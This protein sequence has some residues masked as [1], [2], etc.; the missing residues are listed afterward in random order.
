MRVSRRPGRDFSVADRTALA[1]RAHPEPEPCKPALTCWRPNAVNGLGASRPNLFRTTRRTAAPILAI[2][3]AVDT[4]APRW[5]VCIYI[6]T[7]PP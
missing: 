4:T 3:L 5:R 7:L 6:D 1:D 2:A